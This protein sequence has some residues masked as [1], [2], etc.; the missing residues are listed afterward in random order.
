M[1]P[2]AFIAEVYRRMSLRHAAE[3]RRPSWSEMGLVKRLESG[4]GN[5]V[6]TDN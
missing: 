4:R 1:D 3:K 5:L 6:S 2:N